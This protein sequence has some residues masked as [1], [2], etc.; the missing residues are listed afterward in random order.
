MG[1]NSSVK[2]VESD[3]TRLDG[4]KLNELRPI[5]IQAGV[6]EKADGS[7]YIEWGNNK[8]Y[9]G[10]YGPREVHPRHDQSPTKAIVRCRYSMA[11]FS[12]DDRKR[13]GPD[14]RSQEISKVISEAFSAVVFSS[15]NR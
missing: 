15:R 8:V 10:V 1:G 7:A 14:R 6:L 2:L 9:V 13:P 5:K 4:R 3:G 11:P 12:V